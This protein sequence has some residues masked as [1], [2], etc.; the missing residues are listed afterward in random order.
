MAGNLLGQGFDEYVVKQINKRQEIY[1]S[2]NRNNEII[3]F[4]NNKTAFLRLSSGTQVDKLIDGL[5][6]ENKNFVLFNGVSS[7]NN[8]TIPKNQE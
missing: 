2:I 8:N 6:I 5:K 1:G 7:L 3:Q 4:L